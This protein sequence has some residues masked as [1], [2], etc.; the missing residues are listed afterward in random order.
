M[1]RGRVCGDACEVV[2]CVAVEYLFKGASSREGDLPQGDV[3]AAVEAL[4]NYLC[5]L[6]RFSM[7]YPPVY[8]SMF[9]VR[10]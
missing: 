9:F 5:L 2:C 7:T 10:T 6:G 1:Y 3:G 4:P 8:T